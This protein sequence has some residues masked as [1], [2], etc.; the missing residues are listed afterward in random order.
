MFWKRAHRQRVRIYVCQKCNSL[1][2]QPKTRW[3][4]GWRYCSNGHVL[5]VLGL[6]P[7]LEQSFLKS[8]LKGLARS[9]TIFFLIVL[10]LAAA[11]DVP[12]RLRGSVAPSIG[13]WVAI[14]YS[15][16]GVYLLRKAHLW[17]KR[18]GALEK[19]VPHAK[20]KG[21]G[22]LAAVFCQLGILIALLFAK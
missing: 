5:Y 6:G 17:V 19:L 1:V 14:F 13:I 9:M 2:D 8:F 22:F 3:W 15:F 4:S 18:P 11:A 16:V 21:Y 12:N 7:A 10:T 20:G